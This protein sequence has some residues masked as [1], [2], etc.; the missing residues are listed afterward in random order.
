MGLRPHNNI[1]LQIS[2]TCIR[3][4]PMRVSSGYVRQP[5]GTIVPVAMTG[6]LLVMIDSAPGNHLSVRSTSF[7]SKY[8]NIGLPCAIVLY[9]SC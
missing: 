4:N 2:I 6:M 3:A 8:I 5:T 7:F 1:R 9:F